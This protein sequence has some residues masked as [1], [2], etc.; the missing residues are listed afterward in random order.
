[1]AERLARATVEGS[2]ALLA[3]EPETSPTQLRLDVTS[4]GGTTAAALVVLM[5]EDGLAPLMERAVLA[6]MRRAYEL[7]G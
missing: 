5:G 4:P 1:V 7:S 3:S 2:G 6:A